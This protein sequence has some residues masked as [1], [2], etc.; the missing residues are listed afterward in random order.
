MQYVIGSQDYV[1]LHIK[2]QNF[3]EKAF[4][5]RVEVGLPEGVNFK[6]NPNDCEQQHSRD[7]ICLLTNLILEKDEVN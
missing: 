7:I 1:K 2:L 3:G 6:N 5:V 4:F